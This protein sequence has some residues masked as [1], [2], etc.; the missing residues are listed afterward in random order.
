VNDCT[1]GSPLSPPSACTSAASG[2]GSDHARLAASASR[3]S[4]TAARGAIA[5][6][7]QAAERATSAPLVPH[8]CT[9]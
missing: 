6:E 4:S 5:P 7:S 8:R 3:Q 1:P 9:K 2:V